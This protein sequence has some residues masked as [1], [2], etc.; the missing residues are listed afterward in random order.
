MLVATLFRLLTPSM[1]PFVIELLPLLRDLPLLLCLILPVSLL[2]HR[3]AFRDP[4]RQ[5]Q[6][7]RHHPR[8]LL[9]SATNLPTAL[10]RVAVASDL[11]MVI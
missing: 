11:A 1:R 4:T 7:P 9:L 10:V 3:Q 8:R 2:R 6:K 5:V